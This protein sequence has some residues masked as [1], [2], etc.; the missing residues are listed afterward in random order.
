MCA[1]AAAAVF[2]PFVRYM[3]RSVSAARAESAGPAAARARADHL[4]LASSDQERLI[5]ANSPFRPQPGAAEPALCLRL[6]FPP[7]SAADVLGRDSAC[8]SAALTNSRG[9]DRPTGMAS[10]RPAGRV[11]GLC[12]GYVTGGDARRHL[13]ERGLCAG[14]VTGGDARRHLLER[15]SAGR[16]GKPSLPPHHQV[17]ASEPPDPEARRAPA[18]RAQ[19]G[20]AGLEGPRERLAAC[21]GKRQDACLQASCRGSVLPPALEA[22]VSGLRANMA[23]GASCRLRRRPEGEHGRPGPAD[24]AP[25]ENSSTK[26]HKVSRRRKES[27]GGF[28]RQ[29]LVARRPPAGC[30]RAGPEDPRPRR[31]HPALRSHNQSLPTMR[32]L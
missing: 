29:A 6:S 27:A 21:A 3:R 13:L 25:A 18:G 20:G 5:P 7:F 1:G 15:P 9:S 23:A 26:A 12:A 31:A 8:T 11:W 28:A 19:A 10:S 2:L 14:Y 22:S 30:C 16:P 32:A 24:A 17:L 4:Q